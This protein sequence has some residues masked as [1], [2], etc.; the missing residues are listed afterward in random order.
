MTSKPLCILHN[1]TFQKTYHSVNK[2]HIDTIYQMSF[3]NIFI[4]KNMSPLKDSQCFTSIFSKILIR[5]SLP[6]S[7]IC[8]IQTQSLQ[9]QHCSQT[10][11]KCT[12]YGCY[13]Y[14]TWSN[15]TSFVMGFQWHGMLSFST[16]VSLPHR[17]QCYSAYIY[18]AL[19]SS[20]SHSLR[21]FG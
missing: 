4:N 16:I 2:K 7:N 1:N 13:I 3:I 8:W 15:N 20:T 10:C 17:V 21:H 18:S 9:T 14:E 6:T 11:N 5:M 12:F 19:S